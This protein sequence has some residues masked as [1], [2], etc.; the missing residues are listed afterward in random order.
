MVLGF[1]T[2]SINERVFA[3][4]IWYSGGLQHAIEAL[5]RVDR[6]DWEFSYW[7]LREALA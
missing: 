5:R 3:V 6:D 7:G 1:V 4:K 2:T